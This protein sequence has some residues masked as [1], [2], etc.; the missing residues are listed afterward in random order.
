M[1]EAANLKAKKAIKEI[2][3]VCIGPK[4]YMFVIY[5][6]KRKPYGIH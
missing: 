1:Q 3:A 5:L 6:D 2:F 4:G